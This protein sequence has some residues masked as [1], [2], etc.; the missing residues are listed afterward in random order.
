VDQKKQRFRLGLFVVSATVLLCVLILLFGGSAGQFL[1][2]SKNTYV[3]PLENAPGVTKGTPVR[4]SGVKIGSVTKVELDDRT[5]KVFLT[6]AID[7][8]HSVWPDDV[9]VISQ[10]LLS[11]DV[12]IDLEKQQP[13]AAP[14]LA[15]PQPVPEG[16]KSGVKQVSARDVPGDLF[17]A[18]QPPP[19]PPEP[20][21]EQPLPPGSTIP[22][23][24]GGG[25]ASALGKFETIIPPLEQALNAIRRS[26]ER[27]EQ[28]IPELDAGAREFTALGRSIREAIPEIRRT[29]DEVQGLLRNVRN[30][31]PGLQRTNEELQVAIRNFSAV[32]ERIDVFMATNQD[33]ISKAVDQTTDVLQRMSNV[34]SDENQRNV[35]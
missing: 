29:N 8:D 31:G 7:K 13:S 5:G 2:A 26:A 25:P 16:P 23:R 32:A 18:G 21:A 15:A 34:L 24:T 30:A 3:I 14:R 22:G 28:S 19:A 33:R 20:A 10:D 4:R 11:R 9:A 17:A 12:T 35:T 1:S 27:L 6:I